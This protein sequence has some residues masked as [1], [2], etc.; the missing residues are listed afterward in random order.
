MRG[1]EALAAANRRHKEALEQVAALQEALDAERLRRKAE[2]IGL[3]ADLNRALFDQERRIQEVSQER[4]SECEAH[5][6]RR[7]QESSQEHA[8]RAYGALYMMYPILSPLELYE[9]GDILGYP[10]SEIDKEVY[11]DKPGLIPDR[12]HKRVISRLSK[13]TGRNLAKDSV[14][15]A[16]LRPSKYSNSEESGA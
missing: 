11:L 10:A 9:L 5:C 3:K 12:K 1:K 8:T 16:R 7:I 4:I 13:A 14:R 15:D 2:V 6:D